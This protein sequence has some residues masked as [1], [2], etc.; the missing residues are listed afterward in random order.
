LKLSA[1]FRPPVVTAWRDFG[2]EV[3][4]FLRVCRYAG[5]QDWSTDLQTYLGSLNLTKEQYEQPL[6]VQG[7]P[8]DRLLAD[9]VYSR[10]GLEVIRSFMLVHAARVTETILRAHAAGYSTTKRDLIDDLV[11]F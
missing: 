1:Y 8:L 2:L 4:R 9:S 5:V 11:P 6:H 10:R 7:F 3:V